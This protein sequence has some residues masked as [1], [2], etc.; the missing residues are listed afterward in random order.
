MDTLRKAFPQVPDIFLE[1]ALSEADEEVLV[2]SELLR[3]HVG[4]TNDGRKMP[5]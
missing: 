4:N 2:A 1:N 3:I 5:V